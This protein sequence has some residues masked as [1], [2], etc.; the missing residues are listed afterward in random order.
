MITSVNGEVAITNATLPEVMAEFTGIIRA[1]YDCAIDAGL[2]DKEVRQAIAHAGRLA[3]MS[4]EEM[5][6]HI[7][8]L[9]DIKERI[10]K[11]L[12]DD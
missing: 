4:D 11:V 8:E 10:E 9:E 6:D 7:K 5:V 1:V 3:F 2:H 12:C